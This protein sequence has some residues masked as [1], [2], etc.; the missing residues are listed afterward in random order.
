LHQE[1]LHLILPLFGDGKLPGA[2]LIPA[3]AWQH[4]DPLFAA[5]TL[6]IESKPEYG[7]N[8]SKRNVPC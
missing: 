7:L 6:R 5:G 2:C 4:S 1:R 8:L 3:A